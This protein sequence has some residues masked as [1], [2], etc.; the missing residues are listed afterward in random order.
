MEISLVYRKKETE[1]ISAVRFVSHIRLPILKLT[2]MSHYA[3]S[4]KGDAI[5]Y[6][7]CL[8]SNAYFMLC[9]VAPDKVIG[10]MRILPFVL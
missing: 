9:N 10:L 6:A 3:P 5:A 2:K 4:C 7:I 1:C 8:L